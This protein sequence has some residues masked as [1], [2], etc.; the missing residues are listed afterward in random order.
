LNLPRIAELVEDLSCLSA[1][2]FA[3]AEGQAQRQ[4]TIRLDLKRNLCQVG[5]GSK[6]DGWF[7]PAGHLLRLV[8]YIHAVEERASGVNWAG[9]GH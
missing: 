7:A 8:V 2:A 4:I 3:M 6:G 5:F 1:I 9:L